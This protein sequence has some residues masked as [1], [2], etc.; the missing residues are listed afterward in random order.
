MNFELLIQDEA[1]LDIQ[2][3][4]EWYDEQKAGLGIEL[5]D[6]IEQCYRNILENPE[7][8]P[9]IN[10][11]FRRIRTERFPYLIVYKIVDEKIIIMRIRHIKQKPL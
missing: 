8:Y 3:A 4:C 10:Q 9:Y 2:K 7:R 11:I 5:L 1:W 6:E